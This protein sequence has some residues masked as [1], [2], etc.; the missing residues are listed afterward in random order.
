MIIH[1]VGGNDDGNDLGTQVDKDGAARELRV[2]ARFEDLCLEDHAFRRSKL[3]TMTDLENN[4]T[5]KHLLNQLRHAKLTG[6]SLFF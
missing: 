2:K 5:T 4:K 6:R 1:G 3:K